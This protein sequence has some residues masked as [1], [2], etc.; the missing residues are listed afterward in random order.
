MS[1]CRLIS[2]KVS[3]E[4]EMLQVQAT[5]PNKKKGKKKRKKKRKKNKEFITISP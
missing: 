4:G 5:P 3:W 2:M 1:T